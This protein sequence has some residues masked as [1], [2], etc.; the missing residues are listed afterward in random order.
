M[1]DGGGVYIY[2]VHQAIL[3]SSPPV[4]SVLSL[5]PLW[6][7]GCID[8]QL[9][10]SPLKKLVRLC[11]HLILID[12]I[13][14]TTH[15]FPGDFYIPISFRKFVGQRQDKQQIAKLSPPQVWSAPLLNLHSCNLE[16]RGEGEGEGKGISDGM[17]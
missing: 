11:R 6:A 3:L 16:E 14:C 8:L 4:L 10:L 7:G 1:V 5:P 2:V 12:L 9:A 13:L 17:S 15:N